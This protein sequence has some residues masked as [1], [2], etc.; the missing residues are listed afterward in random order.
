MREGSAPASFDNYVAE[1]WHSNRPNIDHQWPFLGLVGFICLG[2]LF[3]F[4]HFSTP[5]V[6]SCKSF[7]MRFASRL[8]KGAVP[9]GAP[10][11]SNGV[12]TYQRSCPL[13]SIR[14]TPG[15]CMI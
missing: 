6:T 2:F 8:L 13:P 7:R 11:G 1:N 5:C 12:E 14:K 3:S 9:S 15:V 10:A 4:A